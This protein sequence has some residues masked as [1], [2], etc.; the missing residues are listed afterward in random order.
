MSTLQGKSTLLPSRVSREPLTEHLMETARWLP[1]PRYS[2]VEKEALRHMHTS[3]AHTTA[4]GSDGVTSFYKSVQSLLLYFEW[5]ALI[6]THRHILLPTQL[7][8]AMT[9][10]F[11]GQIRAGPVTFNVI[12]TIERMKNWDVQ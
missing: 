9:C 8:P 6:C 11:S 10:C 7:R 3:R 12:V 5:N 1:N 4:Q 2:R